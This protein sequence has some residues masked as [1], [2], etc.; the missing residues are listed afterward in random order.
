MMPG[1]M[2]QMVF[3]GEASVVSALHDH[4]QSKMPR[5]PH[6]AVKYQTRLKENADGVT[7]RMS[8]EVPLEFFDEFLGDGW[9]PTGTVPLD[10]ATCNEPDGK[11]IGRYLTDYLGSK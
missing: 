3:S 6:G 8:V 5:G 2:I 7:A 10:S 1:G 11:P 4:V 9:R